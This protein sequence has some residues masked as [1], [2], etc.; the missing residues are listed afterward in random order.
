MSERT[1]ALADAEAQF[2]AA[3][4]PFPSIPAAF[5]ERFRRVSEWVFGTREDDR[6]PTGPMWFLKEAVAREAPDYVLLGQGG[7][8]AASQAIHFYL[9]QRPLAVFIQYGWLNVYG[10]DHESAR[11]FGAALQATDELIAAAAGATA[12]GVLGEAHTLAI[13]QSDL[14]QGMW[15]WFAE[16]ASRD[17]VL[18]ADWHQADDAIRAATAALN[19]AVA[20]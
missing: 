7:S 15:Y 10:D 9:V 2:T 20:S 16:P 3:G 6:N 18:Q 4:L 13:L 1:A 19:A 12:D 11:K 5:R 8:G 14:E 17:D